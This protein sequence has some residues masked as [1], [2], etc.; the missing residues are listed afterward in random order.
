[1][2]YAVLNVATSFGDAVGFRNWSGVRLGQF[3]SSGAWRRP[4]AIL[5]L[6]AVM[7]VGGGEHD[8]DLD[9]PSTSAGVVGNVAPNATVSRFFERTES[10]GSHDGSPGQGRSGLRTGLTGCD[11]LTMLRGF[12]VEP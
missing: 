5:G 11:P 4:S 7:S 6:L 10:R 2:S 8:S 1:M 12:A 3:V 9:I